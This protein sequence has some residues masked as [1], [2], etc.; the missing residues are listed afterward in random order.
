[1]VG[2]LSGPLRTTGDTFAP[3]AVRRSSAGGDV[4]RLQQTVAGVPVLGGEVV[5][6]LDPNGATRSVHSET[7]PSAAPST[8]AR[9]PSSLAATR[10]VAAVVLSTKARAGDLRTTAPTLAIYDPRIFGAPGVQRATLVW[11]TTVRSSTDRSID[12]LVLVDATRGF[13]TLDLDQ[14]GRATTFPVCDADG[15]A[16]NVPCGA[17]ALAD[18]GMFGPTDDA[19]R[20]V[21][22]ASATYDFYLNYLGRDSVNGHGMPLVST[23]RYC[24]P[25]TPAQCPYDNAFWDGTQMVYGA[26]YPQADDVVAHELTHGVTQYNSGLYYYFQSGAIN[27]SL[28]DIFGEYID[29][30]NVVAG[31][32]DGTQYDWQIGED[33]PGG[34]IRDMADPTI[35][36][37]GF[38]QPDRTGSPFYESHTNAGSDAGFDSGGVHGNS[39][40][41]NK[42]GYLL[43]N[44]AGFTV[45]A[46][47]D[48][49]INVTGLGIPKAARII[50]DASLLLTSGA[51]YRAFASAL[52]SSCAALQA[53]AVVPSG[54]PV[55]N[56]PVTSA[57]CNQVNNAILATQMDAAPLNVPT[58][59]AP[60]CSAGQVTTTT[61]TDAME[62]TRSGNWQ[63]KGGAG[64]VWRPTYVKGSGALWFYGRSTNPYGADQVYA[65]SG[66]NNLWGDDPDLSD[67]V[68]FTTHPQSYDAQIVSRPLKVPA[69]GTSFL[70]FE[71]AFGFDSGGSPSTNYDGGRVEYT[72][73]AGTTWRDA[74][75]LFVNNGYGFNTVTRSNS[76]LAPDNP[77]HGQPAFTRHSQGYVASRIGLSALAGRT[78]QFR[79]RIT[80]GSSVGDYGWFVDDVKLYACGPLAAPTAPSLVLTSPVT[81]TWPVTDIDPS[82]VTA[83]YQ[84]TSAK[85]GAVLPAYGPPTP[86]VGRSVKVAVPLGGGA[87]CVR[88]QGATGPPTNLSSSGATCFA[89][90]VDDRRLTRAGTWTLPRSTASYASTLSVSR[91]RGATLTLPA[92]RGTH[93]LILATKLV[94]GGTI[95]V[96]IGNRYST[97]VS[98]ATTGSAKYKQVID[99]KL[100]GLTG[101]RITLRVMTSGKYV[102]IDGLGVRP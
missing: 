4:V 49:L 93:L 60:V 18:S 76:V 50:Y 73:D 6:D 44:P 37:G 85:V 36:I 39:G 3:K 65:T 1:V 29:Q 23:V 80:A 81:V 34:R 68:T 13:I 55:Q 64:L 70:R 98:L 88:V 71:Q 77:L 20:A 46:G 89:T 66:G 100:S 86:A 10:A 91:T 51:D 90:P 78:V 9:V 47:V 40:V 14:L 16:L 54:G 21:D 33:L 12:H 57:D 43:G 41:G 25:V 27:E 22:Y 19:Q 17:N 62:N 7:L 35:Q 59:D 28:S 95:G 74:G 63:R 56:T 11:Q 94:G 30:V 15:T 8:T 102:A 83:S 79:F 72:T 42:L 53:G 82:T 24:P 31:T 101:G 75:P 87:T 52:R 61:F 5:V 58:V 99:L 26:H 45:S 69:T 84:V 67:V 97:S 92:G 32:K 96:Y 38:S 2:S 48:N